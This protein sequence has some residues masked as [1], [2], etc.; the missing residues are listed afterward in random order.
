M[1]DAEQ[2]RRFRD[3]IGD[4]M[5]QW[6]ISPM[7]LQSIS[8]WEDYSRA[9]DTMLVHTDIPEARWHVVE[10][11]DKRSARINMISHLLSSVPWQQ[12]EKEPLVLP[13][14]PAHTGYERPPRDE[15]AYVPDVAARLRG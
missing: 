8:R 13:A 9:K 4:P 7:D 14:R 15:S 2:E 10:S 3:R 12:V 6:K 5:K 11:D 1:S